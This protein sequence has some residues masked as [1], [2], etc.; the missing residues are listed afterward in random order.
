MPDYQRAFVG[1]ARFPERLNV[2]PDRETE[3]LSMRR[4]SVYDYARW[5]EGFLASL[6]GWREV[7][8]MTRLSVI[9]RSSPP[10][11]FSEGVHLARDGLVLDG[12]AARVT[13]ANAS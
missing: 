10:P 11:S 8:S 2:F 5:I 13:S 7:S 9:S 12:A 1:A 3:Y 6:K 4:S